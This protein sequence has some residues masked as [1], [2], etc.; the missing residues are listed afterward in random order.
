MGGECQKLCGVLD[1]EAEVGSLRAKDLEAE[2][3][4]LPLNMKASRA[5]PEEYFS[6]DYKEV[7]DTAAPN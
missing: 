6:R 1:S 4:K 3:S 5:V 7:I 2:N